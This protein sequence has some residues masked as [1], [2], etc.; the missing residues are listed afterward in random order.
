MALVDPVGAAL[1][2][3]DPLA[4]IRDSPTAIRRRLPAMVPTREVST[5]STGG[6]PTA[7]GTAWSASSARGAHPL[8]VAHQPCVHGRTLIA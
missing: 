2:E 6:T 4:L 8:R 3:V 5:M 1:V 7:T